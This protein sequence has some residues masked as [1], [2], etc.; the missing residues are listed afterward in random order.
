TRI[1]SNSGSTAIAAP[2]SA[3]KHSDRAPPA[4]HSTPASAPLRHPAGREG[5]GDRERLDARIPVAEAGVGEVRR[6]GAEA[7]ARL[8]FVGEVDRRA[9]LEALAEVLAV[10]G[11]VAAA[12]DGDVG[13][14]A[15]AEREVAR[16]AGAQVGAS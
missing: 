16:E 15:L 3:A 6:R 7:H 13:V 9:E 4:A 5:D 10:P 11:L 1:S 14:P 12:G 8:R 2:P